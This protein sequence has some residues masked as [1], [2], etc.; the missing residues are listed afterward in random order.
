M[1]MCIAKY[2]IL[3]RG[4]SDTHKDMEHTY[5]VT[6]RYFYWYTDN[7]YVAFCCDPR[8]H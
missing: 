2:I 5:E 1:W 7:N 6:T 4:K 3:C 8:M